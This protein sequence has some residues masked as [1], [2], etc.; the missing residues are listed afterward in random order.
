M[1]HLEANNIGLIFDTEKRKLRNVKDEVKNSFLGDVKLILVLAME[2]HMI[3]F[4]YWFET[5][6]FEFE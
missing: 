4:I 2:E 3:V 6:F 1:D 5:Y